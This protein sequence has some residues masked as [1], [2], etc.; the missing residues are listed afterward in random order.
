[1]RELKR[2]RRRANLTQE[3]MV[4]ELTTFAQR[5]YAEGSIS[6]PPTFTVRNLR[7]LENDEPPPWPHPATR[8]VLAA[9]W[10]CP[11]GDLGL[12]P[13]ADE[14]GSAVLAPVPL[15]SQVT[16]PVPL[17]VTAGASPLTDGAL[18]PWLA[19][20]TTAINRSG[21]WRIAP[22]E[23]ELLSDAADDHYAIDQQFGADR[24]WRPTRAH[25]L[26]THHMID[27]GIYDETLGQRLLS[28]AGKLTT[29]L[30]W[31]CYDAGLQA[32]ARQYFSEA[33]NA[34]NYTGDDILASR[35]LSNMARQAVDLQKGREAVR[36]AK[37]GQM[38]AELWGA[39]SRVHA[40]LAIREAQGHA[41]VGNVSDTELAIK[42]AWQKWE[43]GGHERD[44]DW[45]LFL[46]L[47]ELTCLEGMCRLDLAQTG[48]AQALLAES[49]AH[50]D[51][52]HARNRG[53]C[54]VRL[55]VAA[56]ANGD[57]DHSMS[58]ARDALRLVESG[59]SSTRTAAQLKVVHDGM[60]PHHRARGVGDLLEQI[61]AHVA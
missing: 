15:A 31:F 22:E 60:I 7:K 24:L 16:A 41:K 20:T 57:V 55:S 25:L 47:A 2:L 48:R 56:V 30:G 42:R 51:V 6:K 34:A 5:L 29:S 52:A 1:M 23:V 35:T 10:K 4:E 44:P 53:M 33:L 28:L 54:L 40:L 43:E 26:W 17:M 13:A 9:Y 12:R 27:R 58:A 19:E 39:P 59:M 11:V 37:L 18:P 3:E 45:A 50:Q 32:Q 21:E 38:H 36:F 61:R 49:E 8:T 14:D 46:N